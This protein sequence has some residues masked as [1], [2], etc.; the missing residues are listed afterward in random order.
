[1]VSENA[2]APGE[3]PPRCSAFARRSSTGP[4]T[5]SAESNQKARVAY[6]RAQTIGRSLRSAP[7]RRLGTRL[8]LD[9]VTTNWVL[10]LFKLFMVHATATRH[11]CA[12]QTDAEAKAGRYR[13][14]ASSKRVTRSNCSW[15]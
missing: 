15:G 13:W 3:S 14:S 4:R 11:P 10:S 8:A 1:M 6:N 12:G 7:R 9:E 5:K 2:T